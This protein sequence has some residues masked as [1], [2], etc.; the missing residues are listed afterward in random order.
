SEGH[1]FWTV[2]AIFFPAV[3][4]I[5]SGV[6]MSGDLK[7][8]GRSIPLGTISSVIISY[9]IYSLAM[10]KYSVSIPREILLVNKFAMKEICSF[11]LFFTIGV[12]AATL[13]SALASMVGAPRTLSAV[14]AD[15]IIPRF[16]TSALGSKTEPRAAVIATFII[17][18][19]VI[20]L[21]KLDAVAPVITMFFLN[22]YG[23]LN[24]TAG[25]ER[26][27]G[28]PN[29]RPKLNMHPAFSL[30]AGI[31]CYAVMFLIH[32][33]ATIAAVILS[34]CVYFLI[35]KKALS[36]NWGDALDG[37]WSSLAIFALH[38][39]ENRPRHIKN[40]KPDLL[41]F[42]GNPQNRA[43]LVNIAG[44]LCRGRGMITLCQIIS[45]SVQEE[46]KR[47]V[48]DAAVQNLKNYLSGKNIQAFCHAVIAES[49]QKGVQEAVQSCGIGRLKPNIAVLGMSRT[50]EAGMLYNLTRSVLLE[51]INVLALKP[52]DRPCNYSTIDIWWGGLGGNGALMLMLAY[53]I[54]CSSDWHNCRIRVLR[55]IEK[56]EGIKAAR[57]NMM[58]L[59]N[60]L[61]IRAEAEVFPRDQ[62]AG[63]M[64]IQ[65]ASISSTADLTI[66]GMSDPFSEDK[67]VFDNRIFS[68][69]HALGQVMMIR[70]S[71]Q[72]P[73][74]I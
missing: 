7:N 9:I 50:G 48:R 66:L 20:L 42:S 21:G 18:Q 1:S 25:I 10:I 54:S 32:T 43:W 13:S 49:F 65:I 19:T 72:E 47:R 68:F 27:S 2:F 40:W 15:G 57:Q 37:V 46:S 41:V 53:V 62:S 4:G 73:V 51:K 52:S 30:L 5:M 3:T 34:F 35:K 17:A 36:Q 55:I 23:M 45:G 71:G 8:P 70:A 44:W 11:P 26:L 38:K 22:T 39:L 12:W 69:T 61:R 59:I 33:P 14:A 24:L 58:Q 16:F 28:S 60:N 74:L 67:T 6:S 64:D 29:Y 31:A 63:S 56:P